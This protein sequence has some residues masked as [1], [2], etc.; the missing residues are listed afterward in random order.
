MNTTHRKPS[1]TR[2]QVSELMTP[3]KANFLGKVFGGAVLALIDKAAYVAAARHAQ[4]VCVTASFDRVDFH[5]PIEVGELVHITAQVE[6]VGRSSLGI[7]VEV[8]SENVQTGER[9]HA[10][11]SYVTM[12]ALRDGKPAEVPRLLCDTDDE[13]RRFLLGRYRHEARIAHH[14]RIG[15]LRTFLAAADTAQLDTL[16]AADRLPP[17]P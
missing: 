10:I 13:K 4:T 6:F 15:K 16:I 2:I 7:G 1:D 9:Q 8:H 12:V 3:D 11:S 14:E 5:T 17:P